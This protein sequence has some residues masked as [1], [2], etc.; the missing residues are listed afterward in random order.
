MPGNFQGKQV[1]IIQV[2]EGSWTY[3]HGEATLKCEREGGDWWARKTL[4]VKR[5]T[6]WI[7]A[8]RVR[9][10]VIKPQIKINSVIGKKNM[11]TETLGK[12]RHY[13]QGLAI[14]D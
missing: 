5:D 6:G 12:E 3:P 7:K 9:T 13:L 2:L 4:S 10:K 11:V 1:R 14:Q 8:A